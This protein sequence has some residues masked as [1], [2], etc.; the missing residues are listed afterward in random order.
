MKS[1]NLAKEKIIKDIANL[2]R[3]KKETMENKDNT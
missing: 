3:L 2:V 1:L